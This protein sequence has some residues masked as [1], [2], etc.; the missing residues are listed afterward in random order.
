MKHCKD[1]VSCVSILIIYLVATTSCFWTDTLGGENTNGMGGG[2][3]NCPKWATYF[4]A[5]N[6][7]VDCNRAVRTSAL[8]GDKFC[9]KIC[10]QVR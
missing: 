7:T 6:T 9:E 5:T 1:M 2:V 10:N 8:Q 3:V 4:E